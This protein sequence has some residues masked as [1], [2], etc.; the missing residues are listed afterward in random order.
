MVKLN[1]TLSLILVLTLS[2]PVAGSD[3]PNG[4]LVIMTDYGNS[5]YYAGTLEGSIY[6][7][8]TDIKVSTITNDVWPFDIP[9]GAF[10]LLEASKVYPP[11]TT[12]V[13]V[14][15]PGVG[16]ERMPIVLKTKDGKY[17]VGPD[18]GLLALVADKM[19][20]EEVRRITN[21]DIM[22]KAPASTTFHGRDIFGP[23]AAH[24][25][26]G[27]PLEEVGPVTEL[28]KCVS[29]PEAAIG[30]AGSISGHTLYV[31]HYGNLT[32]NIKPELLEKAGLKEGDV[33][34]ITMRAGPALTDDVGLK[35]GEILTITEV[36]KK[37]TARFSKAYGD[38]TQGAFVCLIN[39]SGFLEIAVNT[40]SLVYQLGL[41]HKPDILIQAPKIK[42]IKKGR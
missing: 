1:V 32:T 7:V 21:K 39:S 30:E 35:E 2:G 42:E 5:D 15:D 37:I 24:I 18:N 12:F 3:G 29:I 22:R 34:T 6:S 38:V 41:T 13:A 26:T 25:A 11:G 4:L 31:D 20:A 14:V 16:T 33:L 17:F 8:S 40:G 10:M 19:G 36:K 9:D 27:T 28:E 23:V